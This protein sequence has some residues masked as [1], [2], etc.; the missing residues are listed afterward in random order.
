MPF[1]LCVLGLCL[2]ASPSS[3]QR[4]PP[5]HQTSWMVG[6]ELPGASVASPHRT[7]DGFLWMEGSPGPLRYDGVD[8]RLVEFPGSMGRGV[9]GA[10]VD[11]V[12][13]LTVDGQGRL[14]ATAPGGGLLRRDG[15][16]FH[17]VP[18]PAALPLRVMVEDGG[19]SLWMLAG[20]GLYRWRED[21]SP[22]WEGPVPGLPGDLVALAPGASGH[23]WVGGAT[24]GLWRVDSSGVE[25]IDPPRQRVTGDVRP[26]VETATGELVVAAD[27]LFVRDGT[28]WRE[29]RL[30]DRQIM[31]RMAQ[32]DPRGGAWIGTSGHGLLHWEPGR[33]EWMAPA[34]GLSD[35]VVTGLFL[36]AEETLWV[37]TEGGLHRL[38][39]SAFRTLDRRWTGFDV[40][41]HIAPDAGGGV[42]AM[43]Y[44]SRQIHLLEGGA[45]A[46]RPDQ[47]ARISSMPGTDV[48]LAPSAAGGVWMFGLHDDRI[49][50]LDRAGSGVVESSPDLA[51]RG[52]RIGV[53]DEHGDL[54][55]GAAAGGFGRVR[56]LKY[57]PTPL[58]GMDPEAGVISLAA[59]P[60]G[61]V[62]VSP[63][64][65]AVLFRVAT[66]GATTRIEL[67][68][69]T[70]GPLRSL[71]PAGDTV[72]GVAPGGLLA[73]VTSD[74]VE[75]FSVPEIAP[76]LATDVTLVPDGALLWIASSAGIV[77][78]RHG[79]L[80]GGS[81]PE[82]VLRFGE[83]DG[84]PIPRTS[85]RNRLAAFR[86]SDGR[87]W[88]ATPAGLAVVSS[89]S[90]PRNRVPPVPLVES[91]DVLHDGDEALSSTAPGEDLSPGPRRVEIHYAVPSLR[92]PERVAVEYRL[93]GVDARWVESNG[94]RVAA[95]TGLL[96]GRYTFR[97]RARNEDDV[98]AASEASI[99]FRVLPAWHQRGWVRAVGVLLVA[100]VGAGVVLVVHRERRRRE[101]AG[102]NARFELKLAERNR[103]AADL[104][105]TLLQGLT[106]VVLHLDAL[107]RSQPPGS[108]VDTTLGWII[109]EAETELREARRT[110][111]NLRD[112]EGEERGLADAVRKAASGTANG[113]GVDVEVEVD[114]SLGGL[115]GDLETAFLRVAVEAVRNAVRHG[116]ARRVQ[117]RLFRAARGVELVVADDGIGIDLHG[118]E[119]AGRDGRLGV[120]G[121]RERA[122][123]VGGMLV[124]DGAPGR[125]T[126]VR[127]VAPLR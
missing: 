10:S 126:V 87:V 36:D 86:H 95:Y 45:F 97:V 91:I 8:F 33:E 71:V 110:V 56:M 108:G 101:L 52:P 21:G 115:S 67:P 34:D 5:R 19:G 118:L 125:G 31:G 100:G 70:G 94:R 72:W 80:G 124:L 109:D 1:L 50:R 114:E 85:N 15:G 113:R 68:A 98:P 104:H 9:D 89:E 75:L 61:G 12:R 96:P 29:I 13:L 7:A 14:W 84:L 37:T 127:M 93:D 92:L 105:D 66:G 48:I 35:G 27:G 103:L 3:A 121:M 51:W 46:G 22:R 82:M 81:D 60:G 107:R 117:V 65:E 83:P 17:E 119:G 2:L 79:E 38:R 55:V 78:V 30:N 23:V 59:A 11:G 49:H 58:S 32:A 39:T 20:R 43:E 88:F 47:E 42:W 76:L 111:W 54:W 28:G 63:A 25:R 116:H 44:G 18:L 57:E 69:D 4:R 106:G 62:W 74:L 122:V 26:L 24:G 53:E 90:I 77:A 16:S 73:R 120:I 99:T 40:P 6:R 112:P 41:L 64:A 102:L 123:R